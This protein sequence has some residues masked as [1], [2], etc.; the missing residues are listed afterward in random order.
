MTQPPA[1][2]APEKRKPRREDIGPPG[3]DWVLA[4]GCSG[5]VAIAIAAFYLVRAGC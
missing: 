4:V 2:Q 3:R 1:D 5:L